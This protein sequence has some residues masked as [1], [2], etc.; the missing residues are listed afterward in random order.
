MT[1]AALVALTL[2]SLLAAPA[3][4]GER[5]PLWPS[6]LTRLTEPLFT[7]ADDAIVVTETSKLHS[8]RALERYPTELVADTLVA[9]LADRAVA[10]RREALQACLDRSLLRCIPAAVTQWQAGTTPDASVRIA[11]MRVIALDA[12]TTPAHADI[13]LSALRDPDESLRAEAAHTLARVAWPSGQATRVRTALIG[14]LADSAPPVR[15]AAARAIG[16]LGPVADSA[17]TPT[18][19]NPANPA[20]RFTDPAPIALARLLTD[21]DPQ[22]RQDAA[23]TLG[24]LADP[25]A[26]PPLIRA[27]DTGDE[28]YVSRAMVIALGLLPGPDVDAALLRMLDA[29][30]RGLTYRVI[31]EALGRRPAASPAVIDGLVARLREDTLQPYV[32][33]SLLLLGEAAGPA[34]RAARDRGLEPPLDLAV[35]RLLAALDPPST[36]ATI[37]PTWPGADDRDAWHLRLAGPDALPAAA[38]L[39]ALAPAW[40]G[41][42]AA[43]ALARDHGPHARRP[44][45]LALA[46]Q[47]RAVLP[48]DDS[49]S[50]AH[51]AALAGDPSLAAGDRCLALAALARPRP[52][53]PSATVTAAISRAAADHS[54]DVRACAAAETRDP[55]DLD[56]LLRDESP[57]VRAT[58]AFVLAA[59]PRPL[60]ASTQSR[61]A[62]LAARDP[63]PGVL[64]S[65]QAALTHLGDRETTCAWHLR[66]V[67]EPTRNTSL[68]WIDATWRPAPDAPAQQLR[69]PVVPLAGTRWLL[70]PGADRLTPTRPLQ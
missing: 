13:V 26:A 54:P 43:R 17:S 48:A 22:V 14:K 9:A 6:E 52:G 40:L 36:A 15:R 18:S 59:C 10:V 51:L 8:L 24:A 53:K 58:A 16:L 30:P 68:G 60:P 41:P 33:E 44:W 65:A 20:P 67:G 47:P 25:R 27:L 70:L 63:H 5:W 50:H 7:S 2:G 57:R 3:H 45:L 31:A 69:L 42:A 37:T 46:A 38:A 23:E 28:A 12:A 11:A 55:A 4:A 39:A 62:A 21:P 29:P 34:L 66:E 64:R 35:R 61:I 19:T 49:V 32:F 56:G 1:R